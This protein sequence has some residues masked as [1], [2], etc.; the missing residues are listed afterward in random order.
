MLFA[1]VSLLGWLFG[2]TVDSTVWGNLILQAARDDTAS[3]GRRH[4]GCMA[5]WEGGRDLDQGGHSIHPKPCGA[6]VE[7]L[8]IYGFVHVNGGT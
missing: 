5:G 4:S 2:V 1:F 6:Q 3:A 7:R 8:I